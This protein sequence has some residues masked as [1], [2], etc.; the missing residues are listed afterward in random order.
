MKTRLTTSQ[1][2]AFCQQIGPIA[3]YLSRCTQRLDTR[4]FDPNCEFYTAVAYAYDA[5]HKL[6]ITLHYDS[7]GHGVGRPPSEE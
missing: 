3:G 5:V 1:A 7:I 6:L 4:G 2:R